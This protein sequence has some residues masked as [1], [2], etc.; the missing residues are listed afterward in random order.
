MCILSDAGAA[1]SF[2]LEGVLPFSDQSSCGADDLVQGI[3]LGMVKAPLHTVYLRSDVVSDFFKVAFHPQLPVKGVL[4]IL[5]NDGKAFHLPVVTDSPDLNV[6][7][8]LLCEFPSV[9]I[10]CGVLHAQARKMKS[11]DLLDSYV[12]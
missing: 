12:Q 6:R 8:E 9:F 3:E 7:D 1:R 11:V 5:G 4:F 10:S 2:I